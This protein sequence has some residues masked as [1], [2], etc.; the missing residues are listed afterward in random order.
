MNNGAN[1]GGVVT[2]E[3]PPHD[4]TLIKRLSDKA[5]T[6]PR[7]LL[8]EVIGRHSTW[9]GAAAEFGVTVRA[10]QNWCKRYGVEVK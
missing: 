5:G 8:T 9:Q 2:V 7:Q 4:K 6:T 1:D 10:V 3:R